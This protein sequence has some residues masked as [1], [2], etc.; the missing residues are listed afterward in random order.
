[1]RRGGGEKIKGKYKKHGNVSARNR[2]IFFKNVNLK[3]ERKNI[4]GR[5][6]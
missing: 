2:K 1:V 3:R 6:G 5:G 4:I